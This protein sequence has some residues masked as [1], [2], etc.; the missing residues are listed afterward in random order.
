MADRTARLRAG[1]S[2]TGNSEVGEPRE[3]TLARYRLRFWNFPEPS[4]K[5]SGPIAQ[6]VRAHA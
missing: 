1:R 5:V 4:E 2:G 3:A 6:L